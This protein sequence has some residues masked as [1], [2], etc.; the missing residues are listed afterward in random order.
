MAIAS[1]T[2]HQQRQMDTIMEGIHWVFATTYVDDVNV[3]TK[4]AFAGHLAHLREFYGRLRRAGLRLKPK[5][6]LLGRR[7]LE[8]LGHKVDGQGRRP[9]DKSFTA[10][11]EYGVPTTQKQL[12]R[13][14]AMCSHVADYLSY[15][16]KVV[17]PL[18]AVQTNKKGGKVDWGPLQDAAF[19]AVKSMMTSR[20]VLRHPQEGLGA[21][22][23]TIR[24]DACRDGL[25]A[26]LM[27]KQDGRLHPIRYASRPVRPQ[28]R[29]YF[30]T[31]QGECLGIVFALET[32]RDLV[33]NEPFVLETDHANLRWLR[34]AKWGGHTGQK[35]QLAR[36]AMA[37]DEYQF[38]VRHRKGKGMLVADALSRDPAFLQCET[39]TDRRELM[40]P[41]LLRA[42]AVS[43]H[44]AALDMVAPMLRSQ[45][46]A[47]AATGPPVQ[48]QDG[49][50]SKGPA[51][52]HASDGQ[53]LWQWAGRTRRQR[54]RR[55]W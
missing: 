27:Q 8:T 43:G 32:F 39:A 9:S 42:R 5:K 30:D 49:V 26:V 50:D 14:L 29:R 52:R 36:W 3:Y 23:Y 34:Q 41:D 54:S 33:L 21:G 44:S 20:P 1:A 6:C 40:P 10:I 24:V 7:Q 38:R 37:I 16:A 46:R 22:E 51:A 19:A 17:A 55:R 47:Q 4:G 11:T 31:K 18:R 45:T 13:F 35:G 48:S 2:A 53:Q 28:Q 15:F 25:G 12:K